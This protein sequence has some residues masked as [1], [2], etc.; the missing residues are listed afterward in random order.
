MCWSIKIDQE[1]WRYRK[2]LQLAEYIVLQIL[3]MY[4]T[5]ISMKLDRLFELQKSMNSIDHELENKC[6]SW[7]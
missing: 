2:Y 3:Q 1:I 5:H 7:V 6:E 4:D